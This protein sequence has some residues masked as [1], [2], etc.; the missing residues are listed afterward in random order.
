MRRISRAAPCGFTIVELL[1]V[2]SIIV[3][4]ISILVPGVSYAKKITKETRVRAQ[5]KSI[6]EGVE[7]FEAAFGYYPPSDRSRKDASSSKYTCGAMK[8]AEA[9]VGLDLHGF[10]PQS[11][12]D[13]QTTLA[14]SRVYASLGQGTPAAT[15]ADVQASLNRRKELPVTPSVDLVAADVNDQDDYGLYPKT[16]WGNLYA[17]ATGYRCGRLLCDGMKFKEIK[18]NGLTLTAGTPY[19][20][21]RANTDTTQF[22]NTVATGNIYNYQDNADLL[23]LDPLSGE[24]IESDKPSHHGWYTGY[25]GGDSNVSGMK[26]FYNAITNP[27]ITTDRRPYNMGGYIIVSAGSDGLYGTKDD[28]TNFKK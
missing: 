22:K 12:L 1:T 25:S 18:A 14:N 2:I 13:V 9:M 20:Y 6:G 27:A 19:L 11:T 23:A 24:K 4:I 26:A 7:A 3:L 15:S 28:I 10:D 16:G 5:L 17:T 8:L 21:F